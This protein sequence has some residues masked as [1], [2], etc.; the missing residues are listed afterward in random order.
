[1]RVAGGDEQEEPRGA[2]DN[3]ETVVKKERGDMTAVAHRR[4]EDVTRCR[5]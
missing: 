2:A 1:M 3:R 4:P 5:L